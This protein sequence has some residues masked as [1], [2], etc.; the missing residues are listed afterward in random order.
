MELIPVSCRFEDLYSQWSTEAVDDGSVESCF[1]GY[2]SSTQG[3]MLSLG[4]L[5]SSL[6]LIRR[7][8]RLR[9]RAVFSGGYF[10]SKTKVDNV[11]S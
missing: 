6:V 7:R 4:L 10:A 8:A 9:L 1:M 2:K 11:A 5:N 3:R